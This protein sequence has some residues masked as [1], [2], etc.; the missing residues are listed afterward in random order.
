[1]LK[2]ARKYFYAKSK[3]LVNIYNNL[4]NKNDLYDNKVALPIYTP[5][6]EQY[7]NIDC[8]T[9]FSIKAPFELNHGDIVDI[10]FLGKSAVDSKYCLLFVD[11][12]TSKT[13]TYPMKKE[14]FWRRKQKCF[15]MI[16]KKK[17]MNETMRLQTGLEFQQNEIKR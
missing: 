4:K 7:K 16:Y 5:F 2:K 14:I 17:D 9:L 3:V 8:S 15:I 10:R 1:M 6:V 13:Y 12:F 11:L